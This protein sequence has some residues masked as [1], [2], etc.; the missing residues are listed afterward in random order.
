MLDRREFLGWMAAAVPTGSLF[1]FRQSHSARRLPSGK[2]FSLHQR[3]RI[4]DIPDWVLFGAVGT[5]NARPWRGCRKESILIS[6]FSFDMPDENG[7]RDIR[8]DFVRRPLPK[9]MHIVGGRWV[10]H[11]AK[12][13]HTIDFNEFDFGELLP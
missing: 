13:C 4:T 7:F 2:E 10:A 8:F 1:G 9:L 3:L 12:L 5:F 11:P 6:N